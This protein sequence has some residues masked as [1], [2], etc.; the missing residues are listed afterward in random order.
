MIQFLIDKEDTF[1]QVRDQIAAILAIEVNNQMTKATEAGKNP[2][3]W[4]LRVYAERSNPW[5]QYRNQDGE[6]SPIVNVWFDSS[7][8]DGGS[9]S[10]VCQQTSET[11]YNIDIY[12]YGYSSQTDD[13]H[14]PGDKMAALE[15]QRGIRLVRNI[16]MASENTYLQL[17]GLVGQRWP[18]SITSFQPQQS[19][20]TVEKI[21]A[22]RIQLRVKFNEFSPQYVGEPLEFLSTTVKRAEDGLIYF[23]A[24]YDYT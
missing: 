9:G 10:T 17:R 16:I 2:Q 3:D 8:F 7:T 15:C 4:N 1:E 5:E 22:A 20:N 23:E 14:S 18:L 12:G 13:G 24:D 6:Q 11:I 21:C 19:E